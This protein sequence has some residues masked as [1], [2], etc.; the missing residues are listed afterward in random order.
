MNSREDAE[1][2]AATDSQPAN[3]E[4]EALSSKSITTKDTNTTSPTE[5]LSTTLYGRMKSLLSA[6]IGETSVTRKIFGV[7]RQQ[8]TKMLKFNIHADKG[9]LFEQLAL[10]ALHIAVQA[11][12][13]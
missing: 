10:Q 9:E 6:T 5:Q 11:T 4:T 8:S 13:Q 2:P 1:K 12:K 7:Y 3:P